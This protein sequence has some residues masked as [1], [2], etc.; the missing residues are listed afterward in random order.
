MPMILRILIHTCKPGAARIRSLPPEQFCKHGFVIAKT[1]QAGFGNEMYKI[2]TAGALSIM[3][4]RSLIIGKD[5]CAFFLLKRSFF[6]NFTWLFGASF[7]RNSYPF[8]DYL[9]FSNK[10]FTIGEVKSLWWKKKCKEKYGRSLTARIDY[11]MRPAES[12]V[13]CSDW[14]LWKHPVIMWVLFSGI[15]IILIIIIV[16]ITLLKITVS[17]HH[18]HH[19]HKLDYHHHHIIIFIMIIIITSIVFTTFISLSSSST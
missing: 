18:H 17:H 7:R 2:L 13:L 6:S 9:S 15:I 5:R 10:S 8:K 11:F 14:T 16:I 1:T 4:N 3:L 12:N 19:H